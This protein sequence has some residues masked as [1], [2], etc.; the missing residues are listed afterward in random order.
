MAGAM[1]IKT[2]CGIDIYV[3]PDY[4]R[5][6]MAKKNPIEMNDC[7]EGRDFC[8]PDSCDYYSENTDYFE[9]TE[10]GNESEDMRQVQTGD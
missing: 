4:A 7:P 8:C 6:A 2:D 5:C 3:L 9:Y 10:G 1:T